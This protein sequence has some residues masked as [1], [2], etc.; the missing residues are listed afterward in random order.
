LA[1]AA[2]T[3]ALPLVV[4]LDGTLTPTDTLVE[5][6]LLA[7]RREPWLIFL[8]PLWL[9]RGRAFFK[10]QLAAR[11]RIDGALLPIR[12]DLQAY[13]LGQRQH[14]RRLVLA[15][16]A[17]H[18]IAT[19]VAQRLRL[20]DD[21]LATTD[22][23]NLKGAAKLALIRQRVG[24]QFVYAGDSPADLPIWQG[25][26]GAILVGNGVRL[27]Q[28]LAGSIPVEACF[29]NAPVTLKDWREALRVHQW[30]KNLL[31][32]VPLLTAFESAMPA[33]G[34]RWRW[35]LQPCP[36]WHQPP[37]CSTTSGTLKAT[38][39]TRVS[40]NGLLRARAFPS[41]MACWRPWSCC[42]RGWCWPLRWPCPWA[43]SRSSTW[44]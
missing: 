37:T 44:L 29:A 25:A 5:S 28:Q 16:A 43:W 15:T 10:Q 40:A 35:P 9:L 36:W 2:M 33:S 39:Y 19:A 6:L 34:R 22:L 14:G 21:V 30:V 23:T 20:F 11:V 1:R 27:R 8:L 7:L 41:A 12:P 31:L 18:S 13:L 3:Q 26:S 24:E 4:D 17:H 42:W 38:G 32:F